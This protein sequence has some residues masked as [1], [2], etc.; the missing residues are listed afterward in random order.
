MSSKDKLERLDV[1]DII[2]FKLFPIISP[3]ILRYAIKAR[4][5]LRDESIIVTALPAWD[6]H[7]DLGYCPR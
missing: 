1:S 6:D 3:S 7:S 5:R 2:T 4:I